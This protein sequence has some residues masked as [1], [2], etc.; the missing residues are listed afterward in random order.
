MSNIDNEIATKVMGWE[1]LEV[2]YVGTDTET[3]RQKELEDWI[4]KVG[5]EAVGFY[6]I[7]VDTDFWMDMSGWQGWRPSENIA[8]AWQVLSKFPPP[9]WDILVSRSEEGWLC[10]LFCLGLKMAD[11]VAESAPLAICQCALKT[12][13]VIRRN[14]KMDTSLRD[15]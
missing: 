1:P 15:V 9:R 5:I 10:A 11:A 4:D 14:E 6:W 7:D 3:L 2:G 12:M 8:Q 13:E